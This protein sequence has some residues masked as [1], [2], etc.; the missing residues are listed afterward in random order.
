M[1]GLVE[2]EDLADAGGCQAFFGSSSSPSGSS[3]SQVSLGWFY[4]SLLTLFYFSA[5]PISSS[6]ST[7]LHNPPGF[8][9]SSLRRTWEYLAIMGEG[10]EEVDDRG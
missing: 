7:V 4:F 3:T 9:F 6:D 10:E 1:V 2:C 8:C 5:C